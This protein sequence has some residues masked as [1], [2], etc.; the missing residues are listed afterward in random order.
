[1]DFG[2]FHWALLAFYMDATQ[3]PV[4]MEKI[5]CICRPGPEPKNYNDLRA[6]EQVGTGGPGA[7]TGGVVVLQRSFWRGSLPGP[8]R[9]GSPSTGFSCRRSSSGT[10]RRPP[11]LLSGGR[12]E[13][14]V[15]MLHVV[16]WGLWM[17]PIINTGLRMMGEA[18]WY[19]QDGAVLPWWPFIKT[20]P[21]QTRD[22]QTWELGRS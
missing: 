15:N 14:M 6:V 16:R 13:L 17:A 22:F 2:R 1:M 10:R 8:L 4:V 18:T 3:V 11:F 7:F 20:S 21:V 12:R 19:N 9:R 5:K